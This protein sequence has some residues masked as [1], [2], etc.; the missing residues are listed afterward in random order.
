MISKLIVFATIALESLPISSSG[1]IQLLQALSVHAHYY[2]ES[3]SQAFE[4]AL[5]GPFA[6]MLALF[7]FKP[8]LS[9]VFY[10]NSYTFWQLMSRFACIEVMTGLLYGIFA[11]IGK[12]PLPLSIGFLI[13]AASLFSIAYA[14]VPTNSFTFWTALLLGLVQGLALIPGISR[15][16]LT[17]AVAHWCGFSLAQAFQLSFLIE[18]PLLIAGAIKGIISMHAQHQ[19]PELLNLPMGLVMLVATLSA[20]GLL[21]LVWAGIEKNY[22]VYFAGY[23]VLISFFLLIIGE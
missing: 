8:W 18:W 9:F 12:P 22:L 20:A 14:P 11:F 10:N 17:F 1:H 2:L 3:L 5:H 4:F 16:A 21:K 23:L 7:F 13:S 6:I 15:F 19:L